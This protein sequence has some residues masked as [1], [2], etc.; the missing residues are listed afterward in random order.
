[1][2]NRMFIVL[3]S[4]VLV[5]CTSR[6]VGPYAPTSDDKRNEALAV[7]NAMCTFENQE[8]CA[9]VIENRTLMSKFFLPETLGGIDETEKFRGRRITTKFVVEAAAAIAQCV[10]VTQESIVILRDVKIAGGTYQMRA[11]K[12]VNQSS[13]CFIT[14]D[15]EAS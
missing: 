14:P 7:K 8:R 6:D 11:T 5:A 12:P 13:A 2:I 3:I 15:P 10:P 1:M 4:C 9:H